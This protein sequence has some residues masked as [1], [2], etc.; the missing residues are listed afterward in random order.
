MSSHTY[1]HIER[2][3]AEGFQTSPVRP[4][5]TA[6]WEVICGIW[7]TWCRPQ[8]EGLAMALADPDRSHGKYVVVETFMRDGMIQRVRNVERGYWHMGEVYRER[9]VPELQPT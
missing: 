8:A 4:D 9:A 1:Y 6:E 3:D 7:R 5:K 2:I